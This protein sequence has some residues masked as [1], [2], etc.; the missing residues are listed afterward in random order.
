M[1]L[2]FRPVSPSSFVKM[3][4]FRTWYTGFIT[5]FQFG[6]HSLIHFTVILRDLLCVQQYSF[7]RNTPLDLL[8]RLF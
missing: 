5:C 2:I 8:R 4:L 3:F 1:F 7:C 6:E